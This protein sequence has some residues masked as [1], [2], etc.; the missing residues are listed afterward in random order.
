[1]R[2]LGRPNRDQ[3]VTN[4]PQDLSTLE[5]LDLSAGARLN[6][7]LSAGAKQVASQKFASASELVEWLYLRALCRKP[8]PEE[9]SAALEMLGEKPTPQMLEDF[10]WAVF[11][12]PEFQL[13]R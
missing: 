1:M 11:V 8:L 12:L 10:L 6:E 13:V 2:T 7:I 9:R 4:R 5:A 3:I